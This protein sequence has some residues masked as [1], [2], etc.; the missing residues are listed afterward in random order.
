V[1][2]ILKSQN[3]QRVFLWLS[4]LILV[5]GLVAFF[6]LRDD[7]SGGGAGAQPAANAPPATPADPFA[8]ETAS[9]EDVPR[10]AR[11]AAGEFILAAAGRED[12]PKAWRLS[13]PDL[14]A[15]CACSYKEWLTGNIPVQYYPVG[16]LDL[17]TFAVQ[18]ARPNYVVL[19]VALL[20]EEKSDVKPQ[21]F[22]IGVRPHGK[23]EKKKWLVDYF[24]PYA[25]IPVPAEAQ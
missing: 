9:V 13:H 5:A 24:A 4:V 23:G 8:T 15:Q 10:A 1:L 20:P 6:G 2:G 12:L 25:S 22:F 3:F 7:G 11:V 21:S 17:A 14:K 18:E 19:H 16:D